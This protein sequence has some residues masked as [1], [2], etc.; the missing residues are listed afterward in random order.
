MELEHKLAMLLTKR[1]ELSANLA[2]QLQKS[3]LLEAIKGKLVPQDT[4]EEPASILFN[5]SKKRK[6]AL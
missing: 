4:S 3:I 2:R 1:A 5:V 6:C